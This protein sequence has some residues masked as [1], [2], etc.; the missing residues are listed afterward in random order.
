MQYLLLTI[1]DNHK[2]THTES[3]IQHGD[4]MNIRM[5]V[6][7]ENQHKA[8]KLH[9]DKL[10]PKMCF[11]VTFAVIQRLPQIR[12]KPNSVI[13]SLNLSSLSLTGD[14]LNGSVD[15]VFQLEVFLIIY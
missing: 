11:S 2:T 8:I 1:T 14:N 12:K 9:N 10:E 5:K 3:I 7:Q 15:I 4:C 13:G 6:N